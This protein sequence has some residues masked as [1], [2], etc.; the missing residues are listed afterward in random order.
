MNSYTSGKPTTAEV[1]CSEMSYGTNVSVAPD[2]QYQRATSATESNGVRPSSVPALHRL[3]A[4]YGSNRHI[5]P[6]RTHHGACKPTAADTRRGTE[7]DR[8]YFPAIV[9]IDTRPRRYP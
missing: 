8:N 4:T 2:A 9:S 5:P 6:I 7:C 3:F 1:M